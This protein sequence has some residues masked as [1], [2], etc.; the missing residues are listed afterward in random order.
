MRLGVN[1]GFSILRSMPT[2]PPR[3][4]LSRL[5]SGGWSLERIWI[6]AGM[7]TCVLVLLWPYLR[8]SKMYAIFYMLLKNN[9]M[10]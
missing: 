2:P 4:V 6:F 3:R 5:D 1:R 8:D 7:A 9:E 10:R